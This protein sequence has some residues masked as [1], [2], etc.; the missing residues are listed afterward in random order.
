MVVST[1]DSYALEVF[2]SLPFPFFF[3]KLFTTLLKGLNHFLFACVGS[4]S[5]FRFTLFE[6]L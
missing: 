5:Y 6:I 3:Y 4:S 1:V 2:F